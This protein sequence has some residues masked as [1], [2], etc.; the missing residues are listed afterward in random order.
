MT[1]CQSESSCVLIDKFAV[2]TR[3]AQLRNLRTNTLSINSWASA[4]PNDSSQR[5]V[6][7][8]VSSSSCV[9][10]CEYSEPRPNHLP[11]P[12]MH[13]CFG[14][15]ILRGFYSHSLGYTNLYHLVTLCCTHIN[16]KN[17]CRRVMGINAINAMPLTQSSGITG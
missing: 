3:H 15:H 8:D 13:V 4:W 2:E 14:W 16:T 1:F 9:T 12:L 11:N 7:L 10:R 5:N 17:W 6:R